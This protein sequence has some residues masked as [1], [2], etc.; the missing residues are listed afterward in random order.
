MGKVCGGQSWRP[1]PPV[2]IGLSV[3]VSV[4]QHAC[5]RGWLCESTG[6][7]VYKPGRLRILLAQVRNGVCKTRR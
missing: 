7:C 5:T 6:V 4:N 2:F 3:S 1:S